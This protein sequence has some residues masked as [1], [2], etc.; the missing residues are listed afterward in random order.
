MR[1]HLLAVVLLSGCA[2]SLSP[3]GEKVQ[4]QAQYSTLLDS[5]KKIGPV[6]AEGGDVLWTE[7]EQSAKNKLRNATAALGGD[8]VA[9]VNKDVSSARKLVTLQGVALK[10]YQ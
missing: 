10:C 9:I 5:C 8:T 2:A 3:K 7:Q 4:V 6:S 1:I